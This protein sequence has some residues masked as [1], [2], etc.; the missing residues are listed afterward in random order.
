MKT[1]NFGFKRRRRRKEEVELTEQHSTVQ[2]RVQ[3]IPYV[4]RTIKDFLK[5]SKIIISCAITKQVV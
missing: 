1:K 3:Y 4:V 2:Y 5:S